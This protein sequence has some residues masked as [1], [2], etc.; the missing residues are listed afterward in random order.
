MTY[1][2]DQQV[3]QNCIAKGDII[4]RW[5]DRGWA[6]KIARP[7]DV[8]DRALGPLGQI[9]GSYDEGLRIL[10]LSESGAADCGFAGQPGVGA[11]QI[12]DAWNQLVLIASREPTC[13]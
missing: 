13:G 11:T 9:F 6:E 12:N 3:A 10:N 4:L 2:T 1:L 8:M 5:Y 7:V